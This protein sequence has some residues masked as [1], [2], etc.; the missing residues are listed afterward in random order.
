MSEIFVSV[1][2]IWKALEVCFKTLEINLFNINLMKLDEFFFQQN[3]LKWQHV[4][5]F[6]KYMCDKVNE[7]RIVVA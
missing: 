3:S 4:Q 5:I 6:L 1:V 7:Y 2:Q